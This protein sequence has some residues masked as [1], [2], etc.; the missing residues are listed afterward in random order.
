MDGK[1]WMTVVE[2][3]IREREERK[4]VQIHFP[5]KS[6]TIAPSLDKKDASNLAVDQ[7]GKRLRASGTNR[8]LALEVIEW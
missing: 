4:G 8:L 3:K 7:E 1:G 5:W 2:V 6:P